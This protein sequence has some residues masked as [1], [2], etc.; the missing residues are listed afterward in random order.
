MVKIHA[1]VKDS[2]CI[3]Y[4]ETFTLIHEYYNE[5]IIDSKLMTILQ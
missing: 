2:P 3:N 4:D 1:Q 5:N